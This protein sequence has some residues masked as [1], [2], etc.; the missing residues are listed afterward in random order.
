MIFNIGPYATRVDIDIIIEAMTDWCIKNISPLDR[1]EMDGTMIGQG[2]QFGL[3]K[4]NK[5]QTAAIF[6]F[7]FDDEGDAI[8]FKILWPLCIKE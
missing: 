2:W 4:K 3:K 8:Q 7:T 5:N 6:L 1:V